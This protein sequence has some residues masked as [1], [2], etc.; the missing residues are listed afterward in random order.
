MNLKIVSLCAALALLA[1]CET[2]PKDAGNASA[3]GTQSTIRPGS[4][5]DLVVNVGDRVFYGFD[6]YDLSPEARATLD[7]Q[8]AWLKQYPNVTVTIEGHADERGTREYNLALGERRA[9]SAKNYLV[10]QGTNPSRV[11]VISYGKERPAVLG[12]NEA[13]WAQNRRGVTVV[14]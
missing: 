7:R 2:A 4:Q 12:S 1:A 11:K 5:E 10:A 8:A 9:N 6:R 3:T 14:D 13:A